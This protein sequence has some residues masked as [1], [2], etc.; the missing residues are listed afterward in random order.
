MKTNTLDT[1]ETNKHYIIIHLVVFSEVSTLQIYHFDV[2]LI[3]RMYYV[4]LHTQISVI[5]MFNILF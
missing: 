5:C 3:I 2:F 1:W 4:Y